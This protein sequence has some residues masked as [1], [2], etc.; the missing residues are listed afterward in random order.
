MPTSSLPLPTS[1]MLQVNNMR[2]EQ[3]LRSVEN[4]LSQQPGILAATADLTTAT[5]TIESSDAIDLAQI[6]Q[7]L[8]AAG[9]PSQPLTPPPPVS[10]PSSSQRWL[11]LSF[12]GLAILFNLCLNAQVL[13]VG[14]AYFYDPAWWSAHVWLVRSYSGL[15]LILL[16]ILYFIPF[17]QR[18]RYLT[19][20]LPILLILQFMTIHLKAPIPLAILHPLIGFTLFSAST[21]LVHRV[22]RFLFPKI[23]AESA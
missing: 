4:L 21:T 6:A 18:V 5:V 10:P 23:A 2:C 13:T 1:W 9:F 7:V 20:S 14:L 3:C 16:A 19:I 17:P 12:F 22:S 8:T 11:A 15:S